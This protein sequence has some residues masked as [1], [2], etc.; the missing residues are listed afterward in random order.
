MA[1]IGT[2]ELLV[3]PEI[4]HQK[5]AEVEK[6]V[7]IMQ[8]RFDNMKT[9]VEKSSGYW[10]GDAGDMHRKNYG[11]QKEDIEGV[12]KR[13]NEHPVDLRV[14]AQKYSETELK[15]EEVIIQALPGDVLI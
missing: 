3:T 10:E 14:I 5:A 8:Q 6:Y 4:L 7:K 2:V 13:M 11:E 9:L 15:V 1:I 12:L